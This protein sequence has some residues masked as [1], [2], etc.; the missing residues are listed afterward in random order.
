[1]AAIWRWQPQCPLS[2][3]GGVIADRLRCIQPLDARISTDKPS[4]F[5][6][7]PRAD[8]LRTRPGPACPDNGGM[9]QTPSPEPDP[10]PHPAPLDVWA[11]AQRDYLAGDPAAVVAERYGLSERTLQRRAARD[12][13]RRSDME[14]RRAL[15]EWRHRLKAQ[16]EACK[17]DPML[18]FV[19]EAHQSGQLDLLTA[20]DSTTL[21]LFAFRQAAECA[22]MGHPGQAVVWM[23]LVNQLERS[24]ARLDHDCNAF[25]EADRLR[26]ALLEGMADLRLQAEGE[27]APG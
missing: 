23:R 19:R 27:A 18:D 3:A 17:N 5:P 21:R 14:E 22:A 20:P 13:W 11:L 2:G 25:S 4:P 24:G 8:L 9:T 7:L 15:P 12:G 10:Q 1:M 6:P 26:S 16:H